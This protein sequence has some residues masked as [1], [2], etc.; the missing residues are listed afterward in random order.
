MR[1]C[2]L[3]CCGWQVK[4]F[5]SEVSSISSTWGSAEEE[6]TS[7]IPWAGLACCWLLALC[8][9]AR[10]G[11]PSSPRSRCSKQLPAS[12]P[13]CQCRQVPLGLG[14]RHQLLCPPLPLRAHCTQGRQDNAHVQRA[15]QHCWQHEWMADMTDDRPRVG[16]AA[17]APAPWRSL[18]PLSLRAALRARLMPRRSS[19]SC[20]SCK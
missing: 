20:W 12:L 5:S 16:G 4:V 6:I 19:N 11:S 2:M 13:A 9:A 14:G 18:L 15:C 3:R 17:A 7:Y 8:I 1:P 10:S